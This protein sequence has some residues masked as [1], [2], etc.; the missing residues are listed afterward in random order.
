MSNTQAEIKAI[1]AQ[2]RTR[3]DQATISSAPFYSSDPDL[4]LLWQQLEDQIHTVDQRIANQEAA[5]LQL[6]SIVQQLEQNRSP[7][8]EPWRLS[9]QE[10]WPHEL[11]KLDELDKLKAI[12]ASFS[13]SVEAGIQTGQRV[14]MQAIRT[15]TRLGTELRAQVR[16]SKQRRQ[17]NC[18]RQDQDQ[19][20]Q[21]QQHQDQQ[22]IEAI[23]FF[24]SIQAAVSLIAGSVLLRLLLDRLVQL[25]PD[26]WPVKIL[27]MAIPAAVAIYRSTVVPQSGFLW[28]SRLTL[29]LIGLLLG[30]RL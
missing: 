1:A 26:L 14:S 24:P 3:G 17:Q 13:V 4:E 30:G 11:D 6:Q 23:E 7:S 12:A 28:G 20:H 2:L 27:L 15:V 18:T 19:Q 5:L 9:Q 10:I 21:D 16:R 29:I 8:L 22:P 25:D